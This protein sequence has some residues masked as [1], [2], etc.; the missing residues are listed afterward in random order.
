MQGDVYS[1]GILLL[2]LFTGKRPTDEIFKNS[3]NIHVFTEKALAEDVLQIVDPLLRSE[4]KLKDADVNH[5]EECLA[6]VLQIGLSC[7]K[8]SPGERMDMKTVV[9]ELCD[10]RERFSSSVSIEFV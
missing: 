7:S 4:S 9:T 2:E 8:Q 1:F 3:M 10:I 5:V 6:A